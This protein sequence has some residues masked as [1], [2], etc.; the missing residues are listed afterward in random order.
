MAYRPSGLISLGIVAS[1]E[2]ALLDRGPVGS[3]Q[4]P[5]HGHAAACPW[6][7]AAR[8]LT[9]VD[10]AAAGGQY[11]GLSSDVHGLGFKGS[12]GD[13]LQVCKGEGGQRAGGRWSEPARGAEAWAA[14]ERQRAGSRLEA[15][16]R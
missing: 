5:P 16:G 8:L 7:S 13:A 11:G 6:L 2:Q 14:A 10:F 1:L 9:G 3:L 15:Q 12:N 4:L